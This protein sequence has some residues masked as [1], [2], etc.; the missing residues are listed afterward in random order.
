[1]GDIWERAARVVCAGNL[2]REAGIDPRDFAVELR[3]R[4]P[5]EAA[6]REL[7]A[8]VTI[9]L[10]YMRDALDPGVE[11]I[12]PLSCPHCGRLNEASSG[13]T[14]GGKPAP[15]DASLCIGC[16]EWAIYTG[17]SPRKPNAGE[18]ADLEADETCI[19][20]REAWRQT[21]AEHGPPAV[22]KPH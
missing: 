22:V 12:N 2:A 4:Y 3:K 9:K 21:V 19:K 18:L 17:L 14:R 11:H 6:L 5:T 7:W 8:R 15:G 20:V 10:P 1:M 13:V 16:G